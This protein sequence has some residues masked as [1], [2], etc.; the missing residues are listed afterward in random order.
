M[1]HKKIKYSKHVLE[2]IQQREISKPQIDIIIQQGKC[3][4]NKHDIKKLKFHFKE[5]SVIV[6]NTNKVYRILTVFED[7]APRLSKRGKV[8]FKEYEI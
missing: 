6:K 7:K 8:I 1:V 4:I 5:K 2:R 3:Y